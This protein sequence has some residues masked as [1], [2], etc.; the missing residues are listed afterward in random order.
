MAQ[1][2]NYEMKNQG[3]MISASPA[4]T[5]PSSRRKTFVTCSGRDRMMDPIDVAVGAVAGIAL[6]RA[7]KWLEARITA[8]R[9]EKLAEAWA[10]GVNAARNSLTSRDEEDGEVEY[11]L[12]ENPYE[13]PEP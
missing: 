4:T 9:Q 5:Y 6:H 1:V 12:M 13:D 7:G 10:R 3:V 8:V 11:L 2:H